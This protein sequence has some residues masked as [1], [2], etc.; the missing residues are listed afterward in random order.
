MQ[1]TDCIVGEEWNPAQYQV[2][3][4][5]R[6]V[7]GRSTDSA[8]IIQEKRLQSYRQDPKRWTWG[9]LKIEFSFSRVKRRTELRP[10]LYDRPR[11]SPQIYKKEGLW[12]KK[13]NDIMEYLKWLKCKPCFADQCLKYIIFSPIYNC[14]QFACRNSFHSCTVLQ[15]VCSVHCDGQSRKQGRR[16][17]YKSLDH[18]MRTW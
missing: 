8:P 9:L 5:A 15:R 6:V 1:G 3:K 10:W 14:T 17:E 2:K 16:K 7:K 18:W 13:R 4:N 12:I 11:Q